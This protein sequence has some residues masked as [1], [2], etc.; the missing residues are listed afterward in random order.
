MAKFARIVRH[1]IR[2]AAMILRELPR[3]N[4]VRIERPTYVHCGLCVQRASAVGRIDVATRGVWRRD[5]I[6]PDG[7]GIRY[8]RID[9]RAPLLRYYCAA[10]SERIGKGEAHAP[11]HS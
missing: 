9:G 5:P 2:T 8:Q 3:G 10:C 4:S 7:W 1:V 11:E 6:A